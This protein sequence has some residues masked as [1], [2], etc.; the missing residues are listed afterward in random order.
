MRLRSTHIRQRCQEHTWGKDN[1]SIDADGKT[2]YP[3][4]ED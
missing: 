4:V 2:G 3:H 1:F